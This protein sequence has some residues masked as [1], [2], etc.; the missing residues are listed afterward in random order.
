MKAPKDDPWLIIEHELPAGV[1]HTGVRL[2]LDRIATEKSVTREH[3]V[4]KHSNRARVFRRWLADLPAMTA[5]ANPDQCQAEWLARAQHEE[6]EARYWR[7][8]RGALPYRR[9]SQLRILGVWWLIRGG[10]E[11]TQAQPFYDA[12]HR[13][14]FGK[15][16]AKDARAFRRL[17][18]DFRESIVDDFK[19]RPVRFITPFGTEAR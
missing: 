1:D 5:V 6:E 15:S 13:Y 7:C 12:A 16:A 2:M 4:A 17:L 3:L 18:Q 10:L 14:V 19:R 11:P 9:I 8:L